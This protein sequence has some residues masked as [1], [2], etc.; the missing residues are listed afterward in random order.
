M[1][2]TRVRFGRS[3]PPRRIGEKSLGDFIPVLL[4]LLSVMR[5]SYRHDHAGRKGSATVPWRG[6]G[7]L[8]STEGFLRAPSSIIRTGLGTR[9]LNSA[10]R[11]NGR[12]NTSGQIRSYGRARP[13][14]GSST[15]RAERKI[16][17]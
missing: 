12:R 13:S 2:E 3:Q 14:P 15:N 4:F 1:G 8:G 6:G 16:E 10:A 17:R 5:S 7:P 9:P 11:S